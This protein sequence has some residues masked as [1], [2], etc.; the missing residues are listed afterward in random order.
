MNFSAF[1]NAKCPCRTNRTAEALINFWGETNF[2]NAVRSK[3]S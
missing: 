2:D 1:E 3:S